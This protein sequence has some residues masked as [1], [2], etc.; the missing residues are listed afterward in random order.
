MNIYTWNTDSA[1]SY[2][3]TNWKKQVKYIKYIWTIF[4]IRP[5]PTMC[6]WYNNIGEKKKL[7]L[8]FVYFIDLLL[9][10]G[11]MFYFL[12][13][14]FFFLIRKWEWEHT[15]FKNNYLKF[16]FHMQLVFVCW[17][18]Y[19]GHLIISNTIYTLTLFFFFQNFKNTQHMTLIV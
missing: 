8:L 17:K 12:F 1:V 7:C 6:Y 5:E 19:E 4:T 3:C 13:S 2:H 11:K 9:L 16:T 14:F 18:F 15:S 10:F